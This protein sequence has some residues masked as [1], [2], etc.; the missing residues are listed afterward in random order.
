M[1]GMIHRAA[2]Q[3]VL[4]GGD[5]AVWPHILERAGLEESDFISG[6][7]Y[8]DEVT[9]TLIGAVAAQ[10]DLSLEETLIRF[11]RYW[12]RFADESAFSHL[13]KM[14]GQTLTEFCE[15]LDRLH[16]NIDLS[17]PGVDVPSFLVRSSDETSLRITY[18]SSRTGL[19]PFVTGLFEGLL[20]HFG[21]SG[22]VRC[23]GPHEGGI[24]FLIT[25]DG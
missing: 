23:L 4:N 9:F 7:S 19:E 3:M 24:D 14:A 16:A 21:Q 13:M 12:V 11:G 2:R 22:Q 25:L 8:P 10:L 1:Y 6:Q 17:L 5:P 20:A 15:N 18:V